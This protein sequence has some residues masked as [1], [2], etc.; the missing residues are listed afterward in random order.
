M[1]N[2]TAFVEVI[3]RK[4]IANLSNKGELVEFCTCGELQSKHLLFQGHG[5]CPSSKCE[6]F[7][8]NGKWYKKNLM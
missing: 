5:P 4:E 8:W 3:D 6:Q 7:T 1:T 2:K